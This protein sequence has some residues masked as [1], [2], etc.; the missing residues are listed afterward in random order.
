MMSLQEALA[1]VEKRDRDYVQL[2]NKLNAELSQR[3]AKFRWWVGLLMIVIGLL[4]S[5][6][7]LY[8]AAISANIL[9]IDQRPERKASLYG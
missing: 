9:S 4:L 2:E 7:G 8:I 6:M 1:Q 5:I 3:D